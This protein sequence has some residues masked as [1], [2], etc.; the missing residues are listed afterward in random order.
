[1]PKIKY[2]SIKF[3]PATL[4][5]INTANTIIDSYAAEGLDLTLRQLYYQFVS[6]DLLPN[7]E[8]SY[9]RLGDIVSDGRLAG[10]IDWS[11]IKDRGRNS[12]G[13]THW[14]GPDE[15]VS[16]CAAQYQIDKW[17]DQPTR[18]E[19]WIEKDALSGVLDAC[20][21]ELDVRYF[22]CKGYVSQ[23]SMW[24]AAMRLSGI[25]NG[26]SINGK[27]PDEI[28]IL[29]LGDHDPSGI[30]MSRDI[31]DRLSLLSNGASID[32]R[33]I[34]LTMDQIKQYDPPPNPAKLTDAR[35]N[36]YVNK[37]G[38]ESWELDALEPKVLIAL[39]KKEVKKLRDQKLW[40]EYVVQE[41]KEKET[42]KLVSGDWQTAVDAVT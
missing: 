10:L 6:K 4:A 21:P 19:V 24:E 11:R 30:D 29:H 14:G 36:S 18:V 32:V 40:D 23:S 31:A 42:L 28:V 35:A 5:I 38:D 37:Y 16:A 3:E 27:E 12:E 26:K 25:L 15:I 20:C 17:Q 13:N 9:K 39:I 41:E 1:M 8:R 7:T 22:A 2:Q 34:A 33:R